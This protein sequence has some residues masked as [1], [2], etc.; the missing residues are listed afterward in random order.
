LDLV[1]EVTVTAPGTSPDRQAPRR[2]PLHLAR[3]TAVVAAVLVF[4][5]A[6]FAGRFLSGEY[7]ALEVHR[8]NATWAGISVLAAA[9]AAVLRHRRGV[10]PAW[11]AV[12]Y[13][14]LFALIALQIAIGFRGLVGVHVPLGVAIVVGTA[15]T[16]AATL[17][18]PR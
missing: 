9:G 11:P 2:W 10:G 6:V 3:L 17:R 4:D 16:T 5:Q 13:A 14:F 7:G 15:L 8:E 12:A 18:A 1:R